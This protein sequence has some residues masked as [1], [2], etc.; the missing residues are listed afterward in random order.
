MMDMDQITD[1]ARAVGRARIGPGAVK[2]VLTEPDMDS[3]GNDAV[4]ITYIIGPEIVRRMT[5]ED[6]LHVFMD[7][8]K[9]LDERAGGLFPRVRYATPAELA[10]VDDP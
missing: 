3:E 1:L 2:D 4:R 7:L 10:A 8:Q 9:H 5:G 6:V